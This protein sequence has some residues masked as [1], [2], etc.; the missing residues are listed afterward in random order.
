MEEKCKGHKR[1]ITQRKGEN[2]R[3]RVQGADK[4][5]GGRAAQAAASP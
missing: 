3:K 5:A 1:K 2:S 4:K